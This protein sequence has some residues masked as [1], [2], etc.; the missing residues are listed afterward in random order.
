MRW[1]G[2]DSVAINSI[3]PNTNRR[4]LYRKTHITV[5][6]GKNVDIEQKTKMN[7]YTTFVKTESSRSE[8]SGVTCFRT[9]QCQLD[10]VISHFDQLIL[11]RKHTTNLYL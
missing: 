9:R 3:A 10:V 1:L 5:H 6:V 2:D 11:S 7:E 4:R 8:L